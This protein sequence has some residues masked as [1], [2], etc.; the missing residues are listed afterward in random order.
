MVI[1]RKCELA[2]VTLGTTAPAARP[3]AADEGRAPDRRVSGLAALDLD[4]G[5]FFFSA[6]RRVEARASPA[7]PL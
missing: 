2:L 5:H 4:C 1:A 7:G 6:R 3:T